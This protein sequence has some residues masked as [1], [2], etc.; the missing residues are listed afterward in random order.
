MLRSKIL[1]GGSVEGLLM[2]PRSCDVS[3]PHQQSCHRVPR[4][5]TRFQSKSRGSRSSS[6]TS[7]RTS[8]MD[9]DW[10]PEQVTWILIGFRNLVNR[11]P[12]GASGTFRQSL[13]EVTTADSLALIPSSSQPFCTI[14]LHPHEFPV[15]RLLCRLWVG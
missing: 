9:P 11:S 4:V 8:H 15:T 3:L 12:A 2:V 5:A 6:R 1:R 14:L 7:S 13:W 10:V